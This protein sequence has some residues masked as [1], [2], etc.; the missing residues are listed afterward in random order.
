MFRY[1]V[2]FSLLFQQPILCFQKLCE[3]GECI[4]MERGYNKIVSH[5]VH[6]IGQLLV[7][8][9]VVCIRHDSMRTASAF[10]SNI[11]LFLEIA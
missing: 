11:L 1:Y 4:A 5:V 2:K 6:V 3:V 8:T 7:E 10:K 9:S